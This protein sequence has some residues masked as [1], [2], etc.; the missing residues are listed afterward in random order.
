MRYRATRTEKIVRNRWRANGKT[1]LIDDS[2]LHTAVSLKVQKGRRTHLGIG[3]LLVKE[4]GTRG[5]GPSSMN[6]LY[7]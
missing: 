7:K 5:E 2:S 4:A 3:I 1:P 6:R